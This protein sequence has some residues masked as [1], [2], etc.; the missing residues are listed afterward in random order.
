MDRLRL[1]PYHVCVNINRHLFADDTFTATLPLVPGTTPQRR[2]YIMGLNRGAFQKRGANYTPYATAIRCVRP[3]QTSATVRC[4]YLT[5]GAVMFAFT[6]RR[7]EYFIPAGILLRCFV[8]VRDSG[9]W[10]VVRGGAGPQGWCVWGV[11]GGGGEVRRGGCVRGPR[12]GMC[13]EWADFAFKQEFANHVCWPLQAVDAVRLPDCYKC[14]TDAVVNQG[15][16]SNVTGVP[17][18]DS[19]PTPQ[20]S[21]LW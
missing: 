8:E 21:T 1:K 20:P 12:G 15:M 4:H 18:N 13:A 11:C 3:D 16:Y 10:W 19:A 2:H 17:H 7:A 6:M 5:S 14:G 9:K